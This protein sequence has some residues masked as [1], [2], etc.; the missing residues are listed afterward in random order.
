MAELQT[1]ALRE[2]KEESSYKKLAGEESKS[3][4]VWS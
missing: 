2:T 4:G 1:L 3:K